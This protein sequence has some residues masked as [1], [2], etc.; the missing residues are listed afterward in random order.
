MINE[1]EMRHHVM[2]SYEDAPTRTIAAGGVNLAYRE[3]GPTT[4][5]R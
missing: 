3:L 1:Q 5:S 2:T 4:G